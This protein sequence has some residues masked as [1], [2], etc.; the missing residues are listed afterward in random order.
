M[1]KIGKTKLHILETARQLFNEQGQGAVSTNH[2][3]EAAGISPGNLYYHYD[4][5]E[6]IIRAI[7]DLMFAEWEQVW[8][9]FRERQ[10]SRSSLVTAL[11]ESF[12]LTW[13]HRFFFRELSSLVMRDPLLA[14][15][16]RAVQENRLAEQQALLDWFGHSGLLTDQATPEAMH[17]ALIAIWMVSEYW[18]SFVE[19]T[20]EPVTLE[21]VQDGKNVVMGLL[22][23]FIKQDVWEA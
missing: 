16:Y 22:D 19:S 20:G 23:L 4:N 8:V 7:L 21:R 11:D 3:A 18:V 14:E 6:D 5:K 12:A 9:R 10:P 13:E 15:R 1:A 17:N 2:I